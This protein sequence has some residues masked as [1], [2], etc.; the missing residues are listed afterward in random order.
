MKIG[1]VEKDK[2]NKELIMKQKMFA[3]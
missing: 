2:V 1:E 3:K